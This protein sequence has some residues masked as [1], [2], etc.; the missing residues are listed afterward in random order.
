MATPTRASIAP[1]DEEDSLATPPRVTIARPSVRADDVFDFKRAPFDP[2]KLTNPAT[3][4]MFAGEID[5]A[6]RAGQLQRR[7]DEANAAEAQ[8]AQIAAPKQ[9]EKDAEA[10]AEAELKP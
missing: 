4:R 9:A 10:A 8:R 5:A 3:R 7:E 1:D 2:R 6:E